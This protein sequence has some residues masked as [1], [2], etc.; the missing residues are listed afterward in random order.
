MTDQM[1]TI[2]LGAGRITIFN[3]GDAIFDLAEELDVPESERQAAGANVF[4]GP[5]RF[6]TQCAH[7]SLPGASVLVDVCDYERCFEPGSPHRPEG[8]TPLSMIELLAALRVGLEEVTHVV[9][10]HAHFDH[11][12]GVTTDRDG[13]S[14]PTFPNARCYLGQGDWESSELLAALSEPESLESRTLGVLM[15]QGRL[16]LVSGDRELAPGLRL[17]A[18]PGES[19][20]HQ[21]VRVE[22]A[23]RVVYCLGD[24]YHHPIEVERPEWM[25][26]WADAPAMLASRKALVTAALA[27]DA[28][29][30]AAHI[31]GTGRLTQTATGV[32]W[33]TVW[34]KRAT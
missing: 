9:L 11:F 29:L 26:A 17:I 13:I 1:R 31:R 22:S 23:G 15:G 8:Y 5:A 6:P 24:L 33:A 10:T 16:E 21:L 3:A 7:I 2:T 25:A 19:P 30:M 18:A 14:V 4:I 34:N 27:E 32:R 20:G 28:L 12:S